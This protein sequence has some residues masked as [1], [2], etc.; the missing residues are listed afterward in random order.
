M[1]ATS[2]LPSKSEKESPHLLPSYPCLTH[3]TTSLRLTILHRP[4]V[5]MEYIAGLNPLGLGG[6]NHNPEGAQRSREVRVCVRK[7]PFFQHESAQGEYDVITAGKDEVLIH[8][9]RMH[10]DMK[11]MFLN[12]HAFGFDAVFGE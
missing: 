6:T 4:R 5:R 9:A 8:D 1:A 7:R 10:A 3:S 11:R 12:H 2:T